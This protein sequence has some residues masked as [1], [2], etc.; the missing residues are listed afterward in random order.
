MLFLFNFHAGLGKYNK[1]YHKNKIWADS[2]IQ[3]EQISVL[4]SWSSDLRWNDDD[5]SCDENFAKPLEMRARWYPVCWLVFVFAFWAQVECFC[6]TVQTFFSKRD[7]FPPV[8]S[9]SEVPSGLQR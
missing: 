1:F 7:A 5:G 2:L 8:D 9:D 3:I 4:S 6:N